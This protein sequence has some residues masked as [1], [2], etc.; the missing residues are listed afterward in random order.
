MPTLHAGEELLL[1][2][3]N[4]HHR[5]VD[6]TVLF[7]DSRYGIDVLYPA[8]GETNRVEAGGRIRPLEIAINDDT[9]GWENVVLLALEAEPQKPVADFGFLAQSRLD[10]TR[11]ERGGR[12]DFESLLVEAGFGAG[13]RGEFRVRPTSSAKSLI[14]A[15]GWRTARP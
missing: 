2:L 6:V 7:I 14:Q 13:T 5:A 3:D 10:A 11:G 1:K 8:P 15:F 4:R 9:T 12:S